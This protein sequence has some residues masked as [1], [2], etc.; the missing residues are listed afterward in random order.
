[1]ADDFNVSPTR[2]YMLRAFYEWLEDNL[3][4]PYL[5]V[6]ATQEGLDVPTQYVQ[7]GKITLSI[8]SRS[9]VNMTMSNDYIHFT[10]RFSGVSREVW[11]PM[12]A[13]MVIFAKESPKFALPFDPSEYDDYTPTDKPPSPAKKPVSAATEPKRKN[14]AGLKVLK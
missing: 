2:P 10:A 12:A 4:T 5:L 14:T 13:V 11:I 8:A 6:D 1:M 7:D 9:A 3:L